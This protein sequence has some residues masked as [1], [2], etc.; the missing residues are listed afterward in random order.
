MRDATLE[1]A[2]G[3]NIGYVLKKLE[4]MGEL[5]NTII[6]FTTARETSSE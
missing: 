6:A 3:C 4:E 1:E 5:D 2:D